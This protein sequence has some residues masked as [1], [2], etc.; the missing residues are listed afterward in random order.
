MDKKEHKKC[1]NPG[2]LTASITASANLIAKG[3]SEEE[4]N[5]LAVIFTQ[6][7]DTLTTIA[8]VRALNKEI[9]ENNQNNAPNKDNTEETS[10]AAEPSK[11]AQS[12][13]PN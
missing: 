9:C 10:S 3:L 2:E 8:T 6:L 4:L 11:A 7:S 13:N 1:I 12:D 5:L